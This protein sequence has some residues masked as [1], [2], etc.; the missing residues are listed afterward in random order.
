MTIAVIEETN[1]AHTS[2]VTSFRQQF[3]LPA[4]PATPNSTDGGVNWIIGPGHGCSTVGVTSTDEEGEALLDVEW[5]GA[6]APKAIVD[7]VACGGANGIDLS[8]Q[9]VTNYLRLDRGGHQLE[10]R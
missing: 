7:F 9:Y 2:D 1:V 3:G 4:Y 10:L 6:V 8:A 5:A